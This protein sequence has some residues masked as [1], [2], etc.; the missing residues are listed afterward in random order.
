[1]DAYAID[2]PPRPRNRPQLIEREGQLQVAESLLTQARAGNGSLLMIE[3]A[4]GLGKSTL[5]R[6]VCDLAAGERA[7]VLSATG[8]E[9]ERQFTFGV[10]LQL[11]EARVALADEDERAALLS[12]TAE[13]ALPLFDHGPRATLSESSFGLLHGLYWLCAN[14]AA[15]DS[16]VLAVDDADLA[17]T[18]SLRFLLYLAERLEQLPVMLAL[19]LGTAP[20]SSA[21]LLL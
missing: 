21:P 15:G 10:V 1:M 13:Q 2:D 5:L 9:L 7:E 19:T 3:G 16:L 20:R 4:S 17:D 8:R 18:A 6:A 14:L 11:F 12:G